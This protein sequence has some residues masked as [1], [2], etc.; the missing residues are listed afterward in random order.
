MRPPQ[1]C[2]K[3]EVI[4]ICRLLWNASF[5]ESSLSFS[6]TLQLI[7]LISTRRKEITYWGRWGGR[8]RNSICRTARESVLKI[9]Q[10]FQK[11][12]SYQTPDWCLAAEVEFLPL[13]VSGSSDFLRVVSL[14]VFKCVFFIFVPFQ[15]VHDFISP[16]FILH[17]MRPSP[18]VIASRLNENGWA[19]IK[20]KEVLLGCTMDPLFFLPSVLARAFVSHLCHYFSLSLGNL[21]DP[22]LKMC[23][24]PR[25][26]T[27][28]LLI[29]FVWCHELIY[30]S[31]HHLKWF[32][33]RRGHLETG[34]N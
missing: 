10:D 23:C 21:P 24:H 27:T 14:D 30:G 1:T 9:T 22:I 19:V 15:C 26:D 12:L 13:F 7:L 17:S 32:P 3:P 20:S 29:G 28:P 34:C 8:E 4:W 33:I 5:K 25:K 18:C 2:D 31:K 6:E 11:T 16:L